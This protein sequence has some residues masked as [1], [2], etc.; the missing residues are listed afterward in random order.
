ME[1]EFKRPIIIII[2]TF[3]ILYF[4][5]KRHINIE[6]RGFLGIK[7]FNAKNNQS[8]FNS[9]SDLSLTTSLFQIFINRKDYLYA[10]DNTK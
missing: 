2:I 9:L 8:F 7:K 10:R 3:P 6:K 5:Y 4:S 1:R